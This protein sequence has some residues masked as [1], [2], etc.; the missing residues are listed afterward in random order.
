MVAIRSAL[1]HSSSAATSGDLSLNSSSRQAR[2]SFTSM[3]AAASSVRTW[4]LLRRSAITPAGACRS[5]RSS[6]AARISAA[7]PGPRG[8]GPMLSA[9]RPSIAARFIGSPSAASSA[10]SSSTVD[11]ARAVATAIPLSPPEPS[12]AC[13]SPAASSASAGPSVGACSSA[14]LNRSGWPEEDGEGI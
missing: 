12:A 7:W 11:S 1:R 14:K 4:T 2:V 8:R 6:L 13:W 9:S 5:T 3:P 10:A